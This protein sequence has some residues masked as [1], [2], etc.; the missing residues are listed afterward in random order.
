MYVNGAPKVQP[1]PH[2]PA[3]SEVV[4]ESVHWSVMNYVGIQRVLAMIAYSSISL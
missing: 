1:I 2:G 3:E 4:K